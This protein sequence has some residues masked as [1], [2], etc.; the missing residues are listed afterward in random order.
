MSTWVLRWK[1]WVSAK[2]VKPRIYRLKAG[3]Y[4]V[5]TAKHTRT[6]PGA[7]LS[8][9]IAL[10]DE[11]LATKNDGSLPLWAE[12][13][14]SLFEERILK[15][16]I[17]SESTRERWQ[18]AL[19]HYLIPEFGKTRIDRLAMDA[20]EQ[21]TIKM[22]KWVVSGKPD[23]KALKQDSASTA[24]RPFA[25][26]TAN[27]LIRMMKSICAAARLRHRLAFDA[28]ENVD[29]L[30]ERSSYS[31]RNPNSL[32]P[33]LLRAW[34]KMAAEKYPQHYALMV[35]G[36]VTGRRPGELRALRWQDLRGQTLTIEHSNSRRK[37][38]K[39]TKTGTVVDI[40]LPKAVVALLKEHRRLLPPGPMKES[41]FMF[42]GTHGGM[43]SRSGLDKPFKALK[44]ELEIGFKV[45]PRAMRR[46]FQ[47]L[48]R[49]AA[50]EGIV[51]RSI[52][53][54]KTEKMQNHYSTVGTEE[55]ERGLDRM[56]ELVK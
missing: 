17:T 50:V 44:K 55:Q 51:T 41:E 30:R 48:A 46:S 7:T 42:P 16:K 47:D 19:E 21:W 1:Y 36:F 18:Q 52:S 45:T 12:F 14:T 24:L 25:P 26:S 40:A 20:V 35:L 49:A 31:A 4:L 34:L 15:G 56:M 54:H 23:I 29:F 8:E 33:E 22:A 39:S 2:P 3:G 10:R 13:A 27:G 43:R 32:K 28:A 11:L 9:A 53:G 38:I 37:E 5:H 6:L